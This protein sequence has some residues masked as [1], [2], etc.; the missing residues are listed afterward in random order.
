ME[1]LL[2]LANERT[3]GRPNAD[4]WVSLSSSLAS[5]VKLTRSPAHQVARDACGT[6]LRPFWPYV[7]DPQSIKSVRQEQV[8]EVGSCWNG[9]VAFKAGLVA[10]QGMQGAGMMNAT[11]VSEVRKRG[12]QMVDN[13][14]FLAAGD[15]V[16][17]LRFA[18]CFPSC[19]GRSVCFVVDLIGCLAAIARWHHQCSRLNLVAGSAEIGSMSPSSPLH[20]DLAA[21]PILRASSR[22]N[23]AFCSPQPPT[24]NHVTR[25]RSNYPSRSAPLTSTHAIIQSAVSPALPPAM[26]R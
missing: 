9:V 10:Y 15:R 8:F 14:A 11:G 21:V 20:D 18:F 17:G 4:T 23:P 26:P 25:H 24:R 5:P 6:P 13:G 22:P 19:L 7:M 12:W 3:N 1:S 16:G 2:I